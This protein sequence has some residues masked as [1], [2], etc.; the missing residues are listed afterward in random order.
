MRRMTRVGSGRLHDR[1]HHLPPTYLH[2]LP[3]DPLPSYRN[4]LRCVETSSTNG[5]NSGVEG[6]GNDDVAERGIAGDA[7]DQS[8][9]STA[10]STVGS[11]VDQSELFHLHLTQLMTLP[12]PVA[13]QLSGDGHADVRRTIE[14][15]LDLESDGHVVGGDRA[16]AERLDK[17]LEMRQHAVDDL[18]SEETT[19]AVDSRGNRAAAKT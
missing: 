3:L 6:D 13:T 1:S 8:V 5:R 16:V 19:A 15:A 14:L 10:G 18:L 11:T 9:D 17:L 4:L 2:H 12:M 7:G